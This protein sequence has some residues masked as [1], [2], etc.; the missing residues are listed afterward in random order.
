VEAAITA[1]AEQ[2]RAFLAEVQRD[3]EVVRTLGGIGTVLTAI[4]QEQTH[5]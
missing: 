3:V 4:L 2:A 1:Y 5:G